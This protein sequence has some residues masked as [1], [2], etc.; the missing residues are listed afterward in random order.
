MKKQEAIERFK[1]WD[2]QIEYDIENEDLLR[3]TTCRLFLMPIKKYHYKDQSSNMPFSIKNTT[4]NIV[5]LSDITDDESLEE[6][7]EKLEWNVK[8]IRQSLIDA[9]LHDEFDRRKNFT[10]EFSKVEE[11][12][13]GFVLPEKWA[14]KMDSERVIEYCNSLQCSRTYHMP[15]LFAH[16]PSHEGFLDW[17]HLQDGYVEISLDEFLTHVYNPW[18]ESHKYDVSVKRIDVG[19]YSVSFNVVSSSTHEEPSHELTPRYL[20][21]EERAIE[22]L[23]AINRYANADKHIPEEWYVELTC[24]LSNNNFNF[25]P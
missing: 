10:P 1:K 17:S 11:K 18:K 24:L 6:R 20:V 19:E 21:D 16:L 5:K 8:T 2:I 14:V 7:V 3:E 25:K 12:A 9:G 4:I 13:D 15:Q 22:L 23:S